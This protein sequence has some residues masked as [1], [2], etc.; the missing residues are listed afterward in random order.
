MVCLGDVVI[1]SYEDILSERPCQQ[2]QGVSI[3]CQAMGDAS[4]GGM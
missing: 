4:E 3:L 1:K 2:Q